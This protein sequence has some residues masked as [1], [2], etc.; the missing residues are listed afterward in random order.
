MELVGVAAGDF[1]FTLSL[2]AF[3]MLLFRDG[4]TSRSAMIPRSIPAKHLSVTNALISR[5]AKIFDVLSGWIPVGR[6]ISDTE[7]FRLHG[8]WQYS[9][10]LEPL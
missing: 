2:P 4:C 3:S 1:G 9:Q 7:S 10:P 8:Q 5:S 6:S